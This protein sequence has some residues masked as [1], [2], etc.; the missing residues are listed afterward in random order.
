[1]NNQGY[2]SGIQN[3]ADYLGLAK[4]TTE[5]YVYIDKII[6]LRKLGRKTMFKISEVDQ[7]ISEIKNT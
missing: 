7:A 6:P 5:N 3:L 1:M 2:I 4:R